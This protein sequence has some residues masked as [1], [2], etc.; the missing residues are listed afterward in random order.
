MGNKIVQVI[1][2]IVLSM[3]LIVG[4]G[5]GG[6]G[7]GTTVIVTEPTVTEPTVT[8]PT[9]PSEQNWSG[10]VSQGHWKYYTISASSSHTQIKVDL[11]DL[12]ADVDLYVRKGFQPT[13]SFYDCRPFKGG[14]ASETCT[15]T[16]S[17]SNTWYIGVH[18]FRSGSFT[19]NA[20]LS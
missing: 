13:L 10:S 6:G 4:F 9:S 16:N 12:S 19:V 17:G 20:L 3:G 1:S 2:L 15:L 8:E 18:G 11:T 5:C 7:G 14:T